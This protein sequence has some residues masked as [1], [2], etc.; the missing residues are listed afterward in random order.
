MPLK[1][2]IVAPEVVEAINAHTT[3]IGELRKHLVA[4]GNGLQAE[5]A[6]LNLNLKAQ[7]AVLQSLVDLARW[8]CRP[9]RPTGLKIT[10]KEE[11]MSDKE[12][13]GVAVDPVSDRDVVSRNLVIEVNGAVTET[14]QF[15]ADATD[16]G[17]YEFD[18]DATVTVTVYDLDDA[19]P[20]PNRSGDLVG[21]FA[22]R[23]QQAPATPTGL[24]ITFKGEKAETPAEPAP[25]PTP[26]PAPEPTPEPATDPAASDPVPPSEGGELPTPP[27]E[28]D[29]GGE[30]PTE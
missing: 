26:E 11:K 1:L 6:D 20:T 25:E 16:L 21:T 28:G 22:A 27:A 9:A 10:F 5:L 18:Q 7:T 13:Y 24:T 30:A 15:P 29:G 4:K 8:L 14:K 3:A 17:D 23:D 12:I 19:Q 2:Q